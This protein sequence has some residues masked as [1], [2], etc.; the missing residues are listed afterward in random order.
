MVLYGLVTNYMDVTMCVNLNRTLIAF[1]T[2][3]WKLGGLSQSTDLK[4]G[5]VF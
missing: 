1:K 5:N 3:G 2:L 4:G